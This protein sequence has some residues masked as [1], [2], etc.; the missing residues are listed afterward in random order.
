MR[1]NRVEIVCAF[2]VDPAIV[3]TCGPYL[4]ALQQ[5]LGGRLLTINA[6]EDAPPP[7]PRV[8]LKLEETI[9]N[10]ALDRFHITTQPPS[11]VADDMDK[12]A[13][14]ALQ[15]SNSIILEM[16]PAN[17]NYNWSG[18]IAEVEYIEEP[19]VSSS[20]IEAAVPLFDRLINIDRKGHKLS[21]FQLQ[22]GIRDDNYFITYTITGFETRK[23]II[24]GPAQE[25]YVS[26]DPKEYPLTECGLKV[27]LDVNNRPDPIHR[28]P[29]FDIPLIL[30]KQSKLFN[31][32]AKDLNLEGLIK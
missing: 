22:F 6:P 24:K 31:N 16:K 15:R 13:Q 26:I 18:V 21:S 20:A 28:N 9:I 19:I 1:V 8:V 30:N 11:H 25:R 27:S 3:L 5:R 10:F 14:F 17:L 7:L 23:I 12:A 32:I 2:E 29:E 4:K